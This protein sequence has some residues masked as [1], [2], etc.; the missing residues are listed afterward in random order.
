MFLAF[1]L[2]L[3]CPQNCCCLSDILKF[4]P[5]IQLPMLQTHQNTSESPEVANRNGIGQKVPNKPKRMALFGEIRDSG[6][7]RR[8]RDIQGME[9]AEPSKWRGGGGRERRSNRVLLPIWPNTEAITK[10]DLRKNHK[11]VA[12][13]GIRRNARC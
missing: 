9:M 5:K 2:S 10:M 7:N 6:E 3:N 12:R 11:L 1:G 13:C 4:W 8:A